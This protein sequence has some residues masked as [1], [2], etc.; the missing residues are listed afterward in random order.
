MNYKNIIFKNFQ[1]NKKSP[2]VQKLLRNI[3]KE[4]SQILFFK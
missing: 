3:L 4:N 2:H 1:F